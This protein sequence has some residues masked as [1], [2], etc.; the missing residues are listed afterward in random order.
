MHF[1]WVLHL[2]GTGQCRGLMLPS[3]GAVRSV[4][5]LRPSVSCPAGSGRGRMAAGGTWAL[6]SSAERFL[7]LRE[8]CAEMARLSSVSGV[9][10]LVVSNSSGVNGSPPASLEVALLQKCFGFF[11]LEEQLLVFPFGK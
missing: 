2:L 8:A 9:S 11:F 1:R 4:C 10:S 6:G 7:R 3:P 5:T